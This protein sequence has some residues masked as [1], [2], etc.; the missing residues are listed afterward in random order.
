MIQYKYSN[1]ND[2]P[3]DGNRQL[4]EPNAVASFKSVRQ[5]MDNHPNDKKDKDVT[6]FI[7][8][9]G[10]DFYLPRGANHGNHAVGGV[11]CHLVSFGRAKVGSRTEKEPRERNKCECEQ[12]R[13]APVYPR[14]RL[15]IE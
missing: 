2:Y 13:P 5:P 9:I 3:D 8:N 1:H 6:I 7:Y 10:N 4:S 12:D 15:I 11:P 14:D